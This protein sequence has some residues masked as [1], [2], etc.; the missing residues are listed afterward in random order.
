M[1]ASCICATQESDTVASIPIEAG[2]ADMAIG[3]LDRVAVEVGRRPARLDHRIDVQRA[4]E[5]VEALVAVPSAGRA[6]G[7]GLVREQVG[8]AVIRVTARQITPTRRRT[9]RQSSSASGVYSCVPQIRGVIIMTAVLRRSRIKCA[10]QLKSHSKG[11]G[12]ERVWQGRRVQD[13]G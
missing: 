1:P 7:V 13:E 10:A 3:V 6:V 5:P 9:W 8:P 11:A 2:E 4:E 12:K